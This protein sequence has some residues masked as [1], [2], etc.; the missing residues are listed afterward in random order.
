MARGVDLKI[1]AV[2]SAVVLALSSGTAQAATVAITNNGTGDLRVGV[3]AGSISEA[4][5]S[6]SINELFDFDDG[7]LD[8]LTN[9]AA[10]GSVDAETF[11]LRAFS[12]IEQFGPD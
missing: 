7:T 11:S 10:S 2:A 8:I 5:V 6:A 4:N 1:C 3:N 9:Y 12:E